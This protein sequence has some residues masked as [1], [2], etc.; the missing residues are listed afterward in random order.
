[1][2]KLKDTASF[3]WDVI[4]NPDVVWVDTETGETAS[5]ERWT[6]VQRWHT[7]RPYWTH[8]IFTKR[9]PCGCRKRFGLWATI[10]CMDHAFA[11]VES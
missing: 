11:E 8:T 1:M 3:L 9:Y 10:W 4:R 2:N 6:R 5:V 7:F